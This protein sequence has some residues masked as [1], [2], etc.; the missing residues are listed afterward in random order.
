MVSEEEEAVLQEGNRGEEAE[1][2]HNP[3]SNTIWKEPAWQQLRFFSSDPKH[4]ASAVKAWIENTIIGLASTQQ[5][6]IIMVKK[7]CQHPKKSFKKPVTEDCGG[8]YITHV[9]IFLVR[10]KGMKIQPCRADGTSVTHEL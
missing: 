1:I 7:G 8:D 4:T 3:P 5:C 2:S 10:Y 9:F 6:G